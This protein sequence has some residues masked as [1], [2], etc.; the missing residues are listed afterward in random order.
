MKTKRLQVT[1][2]REPAILDLT[3]EVEAFV[4]A[5]G[6]GLVNISLPHATAGLALMELGAGSE[7]DLLHRLEALL[8]RS[9]RY[10]HS[11]GPPG[12][13]ASHLLPAFLAPTLT[14]PVLSG[15]VSLG[16]WQSIVLVDTN[17]DNTRREVLLAFLSN[18]R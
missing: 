1:T 9:H 3:G 11:H 18:T 10:V 7:A 8:P 16:T 13:G 6:D 15:R 5:E 12:H 17:A 2:G 14:L 4:R